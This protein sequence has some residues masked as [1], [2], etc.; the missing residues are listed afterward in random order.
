MPLYL[1]Q[2]ENAQ[3]QQN[4]FNDLIET[5]HMLLGQ[6][7]R[8]S[9]T[10]SRK[11]QQLRSIMSE[12]I[13]LLLADL[14]S[15]PQLTVPNYLTEVGRFISPAEMNYFLHLHLTG[16]I[17]FHSCSSREALSSQLEWMQDNP[18]Q[19]NASLMHIASEISHSPDKMLNYLL[20]LS[21]DPSFTGWKYSLLI[22]NTLLQSSTE[23]RILLKSEYF[24]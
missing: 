18:L 19:K 20:K 15:S 23:L 12:G 3:E 8:H 2:L 1:I 9:M 24:E 14:T 22:L 11:V 17:Q 13:T 16:L 10:D 4:I 5:E 7:I 21:E 6:V